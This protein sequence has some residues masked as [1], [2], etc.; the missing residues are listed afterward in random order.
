MNSITLRSFS[1]ELEKI[2]DAG[3]IAELAGLGMLAAPHVYTGVTGKEPKKSTTRKTELAGLGILA[4]PS[5]M[6]LLS[7]K[8][9][10]VVGSRSGF[11]SSSGS[12]T[13]GTAHDA[14]PGGRFNSPD[15]HKNEAG[16]AAGN[17]LAAKRTAAMKSAKLPSAGP[18]VNAARPSAQAAAGGVMARIGKA[19]GRG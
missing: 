18:V 9:S 8:A 3:H 1:A 16:A 5:A 4:A 15:W 14:V 11:N 10:S 6:K 19:F 7:K 2:A 13:R 12:L 17:A